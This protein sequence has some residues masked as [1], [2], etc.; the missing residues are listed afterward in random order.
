MT[1]RTKREA[2]LASYKHCPNTFAKDSKN[3]TSRDTPA[4]LA[5]G[6]PPALDIVSTERRLGAYGNDLASFRLCAVTHAHLPT[7]HMKLKPAALAPEP[8]FDAIYPRRP[9]REFIQKMRALKN[10][11]LLTGP[12]LIGWMCR[13]ARHRPR[14]FAALQEQ[15]CTATNPPQ[16]PSRAHLKAP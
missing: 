1:W 3:H 13:T 11:R 12:A 14:V 9:R 16:G 4:S 8:P 6:R 2:T 10:T 5:I 7:N 15:L